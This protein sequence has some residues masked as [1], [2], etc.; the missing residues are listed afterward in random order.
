MPLK[1]YFLLV[2]IE[3]DVNSS[4]VF[5]LGMVEAM[6]FDPPTR[7][8]LN[9]EATDFSQ[10][11]S[12]ERSGY[13]EGREQQTLVTVIIFVVTTCTIALAPTFSYYC[14]SLS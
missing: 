2:K 11:E 10:V 9:Q 6:P 8:R 7:L 13:T 1:R 5:N 3:I 4:A 12:H 14:R